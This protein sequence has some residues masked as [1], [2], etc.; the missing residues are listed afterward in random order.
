MNNSF[1]G[2]TVSDAQ[3]YLREAFTCDSCCMSGKQEFYPSDTG[4]LLVQYFPDGD[5]M[6]R[7]KVEYRFIDPAQTRLKEQSNGSGPTIQLFTHGWKKKVWNR[8]EL[9]AHEN[10]NA[11][12]LIFGKKGYKAQDLAE[13][14]HILVNNAGSG[15][16]RDGCFIA[17]AVYG[18][19][20]A[21]EV[22]VLR[23]FRDERILSSGIGRV[24]VKVYY[25]VSPALAKRLL[26]MPRSSFL[27]R[28]ILLDP[29][30]SIV[31]TFLKQQWKRGQ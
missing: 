8:D 13:A 25:Q 9:N 31:Q 19:E 27:V 18:S 16:Q 17:T 2:Q 28:R 7:K 4:L 14:M 15:S 3:E 11:D 5:V 12:V 24:F 21:V 23:R 6:Y 10:W 30:V 1:S 22:Q 20:T 26:N 29:V